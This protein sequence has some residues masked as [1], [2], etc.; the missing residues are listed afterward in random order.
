[1]N[2]L[3]GKEFNQETCDL[4]LMLDTV[5]KLPGCVDYRSSLMYGGSFMDS[6]EELVMVD[7]RQENTSVITTKA[8]Q[9]TG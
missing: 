9:L 2:C 4:M 1:M 3:V 6:M 5:S 8:A 7:S